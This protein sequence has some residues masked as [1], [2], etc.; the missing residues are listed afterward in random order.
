MR[1]A[2]LGAT[3]LVLVGCGESEEDICDRGYEEG[4]SD[5]QF[6]VCWELRGISPALKDRLGNCHGY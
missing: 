1:Y 3:L 4:Y 6:D 5:G 2:I